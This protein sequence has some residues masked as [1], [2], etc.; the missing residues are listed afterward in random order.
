MWYRFVGPFVP[1]KERSAGQAK[2]FTNI[3][4]KNLDPSV[5]EKELNDMFVPFGPGICFLFM[6]TIKII[7]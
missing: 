3:F 1:R 7:L 6:V 4:V 5:T 2:E